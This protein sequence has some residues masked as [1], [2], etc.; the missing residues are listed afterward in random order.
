[1]PKMFLVDCGVDSS[2]NHP[3]APFNISPSDWKLLHWH[4]VSNGVSR[5]ESLLA[6]DPYSKNRKS[7]DN[8]RGKEEY[9]SSIIK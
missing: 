9:Y 7:C 8:N 2:W 4:A 1:M 3:L 5:L 6:P